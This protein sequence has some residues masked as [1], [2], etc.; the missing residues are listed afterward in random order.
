M[1]NRKD[2]IRTRSKTLRRS[3][4]PD[5]LFNYSTASSESDINESRNTKLN[6]TLQA[7]S[8][9][10]Q[11]KISTTIENSNQ[12]LIPDGSYQLTPIA[13]RNPFI[14]NSEQRNISSIYSERPIQPN[15]RLE[16]IINQTSFQILE[17]P[18]I[19]NTTDL[20]HRKYIV[21]QF[22]RKF[23]FTNFPLV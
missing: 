15:S 19:Q 5:N 23:I 22:G 12:E 9:P 17:S 18:I 4:S 13:P 2:Q 6:E 16:S 3:T 1:S 20:I 8:T 21:E 11:Q 7:N 14:E 10:V